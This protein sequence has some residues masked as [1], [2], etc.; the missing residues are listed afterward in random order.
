MFCVLENKQQIS[1]SPWQAAST[2]VH[3]RQAL[4]RSD[5]MSMTYQAALVCPIRVSNNWSAHQFPTMLGLF[6][7]TNLLILEQC[8]MPPLTDILTA[9]ST[10]H[11]YPI[12]EGT[13]PTST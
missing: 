9:D 13:D 3:G 2:A 8:S 12:S 7:A 1:L 5:P 6:L 4:E 10:L 11:L